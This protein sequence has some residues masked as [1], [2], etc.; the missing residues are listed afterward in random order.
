M[1]LFDTDVITNILKKK[2]FSKLTDRL[3]PLSKSEQ[4]ISTITI[5]EIVYGAH[6]SS[7]KDF[8]LQNL[9]K[10]LIPSVNILTFD[11]RAAYV[12]GMLR[13]RLEM[14]GQ[15]IALVNLE[16]ASIAVANDLILITG[17]I[18]HFER[19]KE[20]KMENWL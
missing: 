13:A 20:L 18:K 4:F 2:A 10:I 7:R 14:E 11:S 8:H 9:E 5:F 19:I 12:C 1:Y 15:S 16:I 17:N 6:R 3:A